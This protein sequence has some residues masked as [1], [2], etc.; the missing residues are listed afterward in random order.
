MI[1][2]HI[3]QWIGGQRESQTIIDINSFDAKPSYDGGHCHWEDRLG[4]KVCAIVSN[5]SDV[6]HYRS[7]VLFIGI[8]S[9]L[10]SKIVIPI[11]T[12]FEDRF[13]EDIFLLL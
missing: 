11:N 4:S 3:W 13:N 8:C 6:P 7:I 1:F 12:G 10:K 9:D 2:S 5:V